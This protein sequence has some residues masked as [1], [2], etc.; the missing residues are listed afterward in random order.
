MN[1]QGSIPA[2]N[3][4]AGDKTKVLLAHQ[5]PLSNFS[6]LIQYIE[7]ICSWESC[8]S[9]NEKRL[10]MMNTTVKTCGSELKRQ[11]AGGKN[12]RL[13]LFDQLLYLCHRNDVEFEH[14]PTE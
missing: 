9:G 4:R 3:V 11:I 2:K 5:I 12:E 7:Q 6:I 14:F 1:R 13:E 10:Y 8:T